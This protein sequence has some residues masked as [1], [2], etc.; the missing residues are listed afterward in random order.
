MI[1][2]KPRCSIAWKWSSEPLQSEIGSPMRERKLEETAKVDQKEILRPLS[3]SPIF[4]AWSREVDNLW[5][6]QDFIVL[7][8]SWFS[9]IFSSLWNCQ[10]PQKF[11]F[12]K[13]N[14]ITLLS[15]KFIQ[16]HADIAWRTVCNLWSTSV[17]LN[18]KDLSKKRS[19]RITS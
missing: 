3:Y 19:L 7:T 4:P 18:T 10:D 1:E 9:L 11:P 16:E 17:Y 6:L 8:W 5:F 12:Q 14:F 15:L 13:S 2:F